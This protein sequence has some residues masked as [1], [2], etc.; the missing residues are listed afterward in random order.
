MVQQ[1]RLDHYWQET[2]MLAA[3]APFSEHA[4]V[5][6]CQ[7]VQ[8]E[9]AAISILKQERA[10]LAALMRWPY[11]ARWLQVTTKS[12]DNVPH[13][14]ITWPPSTNSIARRPF[15]NSLEPLCKPTNCCSAPAHKGLVVSLNHLW[16]PRKTA[17]THVPKRRRTQTI[18]GRGLELAHPRSA[19][20]N[21]DVAE[22]DS[23]G[24]VADPEE[25]N[26]EGHWVC[27]FSLQ[28]WAAL[29]IYS[30]G[31]RATTTL[32]SSIVHHQI[33]YLCQIFPNHLLHT[34]LSTRC[35]PMLAIH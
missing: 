18:G 15:V 1:Q 7:K 31:G 33:Q 34:R 16:R 21:A 23:V 22:G 35:L 25:L 26:W 3:L 11:L 5:S 32:F 14:G 9:V 2:A 28:N 30:V 12:V 10:V 29:G 6:W 27:I 13:L 19:G 24:A 17:W 4:R 20:S 8:R